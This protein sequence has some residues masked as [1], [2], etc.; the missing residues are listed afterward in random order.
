MKN[1]ERPFKKREILR[2][3]GTNKL[4]K[5][6]GIFERIREDER[7]KNRKKERITKRKER[8]KKEEIEEEQPT[9]TTIVFYRCLE[10]LSFLHQH[11]RQVS[12]SPP[13]FS[14]SPLALLF[15]CNMNS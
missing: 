15:T 13:S 3:E 4:K 6:G 2:E 8:E 12:P 9:V 1:K 11:H 10:S 7:K 5:R 14:S